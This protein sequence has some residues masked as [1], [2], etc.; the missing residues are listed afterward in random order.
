[1]KISDEHIDESNFE[2]IVLA[3]CRQVFD[4]KEFEENYL[5]DGIEHDGIYVGEFD[6]NIVEITVSKKEGKAQSDLSKLKKRIEGLQRIYAGKK[7]IRGWF[8]TRYPLSPEQRKRLQEY[9]KNIIVHQDYHE[10]VGRLVD[11]K[12]YLSARSNYQFGSALNLFTEGHQFEQDLFVE[13]PL[14]ELLQKDRK[15]SLGQLIRECLKGTARR[16]LLT[17]DFGSGKSMHLR[18]LFV[19]LSKNHING[20]EDRFPIAINL[21]DCSQLESPDEAIRRHADRIGTPE[22]AE[23][24]IRAW[25]A[26]FA[27]VL[28]DGF[29]ELVPRQT[30]RPNRKINRRYQD[31]RKQALLIVRRFVSETPANCLLVITGRSHYFDSHDEMMEGI[32]EANDWRHFVLDDLASSDET[33]RFLAKYGSAFQPPE[34]LPRKPL[35][36]GYLAVLSQNDDLMDIGGLS[37]ARGWSFLLEK[38]CRREIDQIKDL[39]FLLQDLFDIYGFLATVSRKRGDGTGPISVNDVIEAYKSIFNDDPEGV[40]LGQLLRL[41]GL[42]GSNEIRV[43]QIGHRTS[44]GSKKFISKDLVDVCSANFLMDYFDSYDAF[45]LRVYDGI[46]APIS[47]IGAEHFGN[48]VNSGKVT[49]SAAEQ[50]ATKFPNSFALV[51]LFQS[52]AYLSLKYTGRPIALS[53]LE[54]TKLDMEDLAADLSSFTFVD[55]Y[56]GQMNLISISN[57]DF[58]PKF[59]GCL[60][61]NVLYDQD[62]NIFVDATSFSEIGEKT[63][64]A[65]TALDQVQKFASDRERIF[66]DLL[67]KLYHQSGAGRLEKALYSGNAPYEHQIV[68]EMLVNLTKQGLVHVIKTG[69]APLWKPIPGRSGEVLA[70][71]NSP[72]REYYESRS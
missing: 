4:H 7:N 61:E 34:W 46:T 18:E 60:V 30:E 14:R 72:N 17:G 12:K 33:T 58:L 51:D 2:R 27:T 29:D 57:Q 3:I 8:I 56:F 39:P 66:F 50:I 38:F 52:H 10:F 41:P 45:R 21:R 1:M 26:G 5:V 24:L 42:V 49:S 32:G 43:D 9:P 40:D 44:R 31:I 59:S 20:R 69:G 47:S 19:A 15:I 23:D 62:Y 22:I 68:S 35:L 37:A 55:C 63:R 64:R 13:L 11:S 54:I 28:L 16:V 25:R 36:L 53:N 67:R 70:Y 6:V 71:L 65:F 48:E